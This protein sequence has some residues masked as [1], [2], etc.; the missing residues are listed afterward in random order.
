[1]TTISALVVLVAL[2][3]TSAFAQ[4]SQSAP[5]Q[6]DVVV[7]LVG[8]RMIRMSD[9]DGLWRD[10]DRLSFVR[11]RQ[12]IF[13]GRQRALELLVEREVLFNEAGR[14]GVTTTELLARAQADTPPPPVSDSELEALYQRS[15]ARVQGLTLE[16]AAPLLRR[17]LTQSHEDA[18]RTRLV[19]ELRRERV[20]VQVI[21]PIEP[22]RESITIE[23]GDPASRA[24]A[25]IEIVEYSDFQCPYCR[26]LA[27]TLSK[28]LEKYGSRVRLVWKDYPLS[29][30]SFAR[31]AAEAA[32]CAADQD[33]F[34]QYHD[35]LFQRQAEFAH[36]AFLEFARHLNLEMTAFESCLRSG[37]YSLDLAAAAEEAQQLDITSTPTVFVNGR[38]I[39]GV[40]PFEVLDRI[41][42]DELRRVAAP[43]A[44]ESFADLEV[45]VGDLLRVEYPGG[46]SFSARLTD[47][48]PTMLMVDGQVVTP[49]PGLIVERV[50]DPV[51]DGPVLGG[52]IGFA[53]GTVTANGQCSATR[54]AWKCMVSTA[55]MGSAIGLLVDLS[56][57]G[58]V[59]VY[60]KVSP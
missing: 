49:V 52:V 48:S 33:R 10:S 20:P 38:R 40:V 36:A 32:R 14:L 41:L 21:R 4:T 19:D 53:L 37:K 9:V 6:D 2:F 39:T 46:K 23:P 58:R 13:D 15:T 28:I 47:L 60:P 54:P 30:H 43:L 57:Q 44:Q 50:G 56:K 16:Q 55:A 22:P 31:E 1:V 8:G 17:Y 26:E 35:I 18:V 27:P 34:W 7:A 45:K 51:W 29:I 5:D 42:A 11:A 59:R 25:P 24:Q 12:Q 3:S